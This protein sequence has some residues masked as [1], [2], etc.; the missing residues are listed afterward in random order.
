MDCMVELVNGSK[1]V[2]V[3]SKSSMDGAEDCVGVF[4]KVVSCVMEAKAEFCH[5]IKPQF[6]LLDSSAEADYLNEDHQFALTNVERAFECPEGKRVTISVS[7]RGKMELTKLQW[8]RKFTCWED[9]FPITCSEVLRTLEVVVDRIRDL[10]L[11]LGAPWEFLEKL[12]TNFPFDVDQRKRELVTWWMSSSQD[13][14][15]WWK[16]V[17]ALQDAE[18]SELAEEIK[19]KHG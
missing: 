9:L 7:G 8:L 5:F 10:G 16:L 13:P 11:C 14:P 17:E 1:G 4:T 6:F 18:R 3:L 12:N 15:C 19:R 2:V